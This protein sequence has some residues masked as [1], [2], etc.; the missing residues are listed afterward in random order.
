MKKLAIIFFPL[1]IST[2]QAQVISL[3]CNGVTHRDEG[4]GR[5]TESTVV[6]NVTITASTGSMKIEGLSCWA[7]NGD[8]SALKSAAS[9]D[10]FE[11]NGAGS[12]KGRGEVTTI[13]IDRRSGYMVF[14]QGNDFGTADSKKLGPQSERAQLVCTGGSDPKF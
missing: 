7:T 1:L 14:S 5:S 8:C 4:N 2:C 3:A 10:F 11:A 9:K 12:F 6:A 13:R